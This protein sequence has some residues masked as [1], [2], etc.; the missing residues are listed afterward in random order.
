VRVLYVDD[1]PDNLELFRLSFTGAFPLDTAS[2]GEEALEMLARADYAVLLSD[3][4]MP[5]M[6]GVELL[7]RV[8]REFP[9]VV[10][11]IVSAYGDA[12][13]ILRAINVGHAHEYILK[14]WK[15]DDLLARIQAAIAQHDRRRALE[16]LAEAHS[17][18]APA[19][20]IVGLD[21]VLAIA[22][23]AAQSDATVLIRGETGTGK[24]LVARYVHDHSGRKRGPFVRVNCGALSESLLESELFG[25]EQGAFTGATK[26]KKGRFELAHGGTI[27]LDE[28]GD[29]SAKM[30]VALLRVLQE[31][32]IERV[33]GGHS[34]KVDVRVIA[35][36]HQPLE[37]LAKDGRF[38]DDLFYR[39]NV[40]PL[41]VPPL[42]QRV[43]E[44]PSLVAHFLKARG[45]T[46]RVTDQALE[47]L[48]RY[49]WPGNVRE[50]ENLIERAVVLCDGD[51]LDVEDFS[52]RLDVPAAENVRDEVAKGEADM[53]RSV[54]LRHGGNVT[55][56]AKELGIARTT[57]FS[58]ARKHGLL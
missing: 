25:H 9:D 22:A 11:I 2:G 20:D 53:L 29:V 56:A 43:A 13:R 15:K 26:Q 28:V 42:R 19:D 41:N 30:Q 46:F 52:I 33:G 47:A 45:R 16:R 12:E 39:L 4:R 31:R 18:E 51:V 35:A 55:R 14:P 40:L 57:L 34:I 24:E 3:E 17:S 8:E 49:G 37:Q 48:A 54:L 58:Q 44:L 38:R 10:R 27:F 23:K 21:A 1:E 7:A 36:T 5:K 6:S 32:E 50:L